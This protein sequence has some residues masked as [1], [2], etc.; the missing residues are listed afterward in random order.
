[1]FNS[2]DNKFESENMQ[3]NSRPSIDTIQAHEVDDYFK[4]YVMTKKSSIN[5]T[6]SNESLVSMKSCFCDS[7]QSI[8]SDKFKT[9]LMINQMECDTC[10]NLIAGRE[11]RRCSLCGDCI[12]KFY[13]PKTCAA[14]NGRISFQD[15]K[16]SQ[17]L[18]N[19]KHFEESFDESGLKLCNCFSKY[20]SQNLSSIQPTNPNE[21]LPQITGKACSFSE[22]F[23]MQNKRPNQLPFFSQNC[24][25]NQGNDSDESSSEEERT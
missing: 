2:E 22:I 20:P 23:M 4:A 11:S 17:K 18:V 10:K 9:S 14:C 1:M 13:S 7:T 15:L 19:K 12:E 5:K 21:V 24:I 8:F 3:T 25:T 6:H 16:N